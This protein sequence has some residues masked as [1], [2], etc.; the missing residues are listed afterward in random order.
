MNAGTQEE[1]REKDGIPSKKDNKPDEVTN[2]PSPVPADAVTPRALRPAN[3]VVDSSN[4]LHSV[5][6]FERR[7]LGTVDY[8]PGKLLLYGHELDLNS[9][10]QVRI[11]SEYLDDYEIDVERRELWGTEVYT[12]DSDL[13]YVLNHL[14]MIPS[15]ADRGDLLVEIL[16]LP[17]LKRYVG[18]MRGGLHSRSWL[19]QH[20]GISYMV[21][22][23]K[24]MPRGWTLRGLDGRC[25]R[26]TSS[27]PLLV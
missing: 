5:D 6:H 1:S 23:V 8:R 13:V 22:N 3:T 18:S 24:V 4:V 15:V 25:E 26:I 9:V 21:R 16:V 2:L 14:E 10:L 12:D 7:S 20:D 27:T 17:T 11:S 19:T